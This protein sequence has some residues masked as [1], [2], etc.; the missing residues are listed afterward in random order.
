MNRRLI[1]LFFFSLITIYSFCQ[2]NILET[3]ISADFTD[4][5]LSS[6]LS[7]LNRSYGLNF[8]YSES[9]ISTDINVTV[10]M[11]DVT[12]DE[13]LREIFSETLI[14]YK[15]VN[16]RIVLYKNRNKY[17]KYTLSG[18]IRDSLTGERLI[19]AAVYISNPEY[20]TITNPYGFYSLTLPRGTY[21]INYMYIGYKP[22][23]TK[24]DLTEDFTQNIDLPLTNIYMPEVKIISTKESGFSSISEPG[25]INLETKNI[26]YHP[27]LFGEPDIA[28][29]ISMIPGVHVREMTS[30]NL[31]IRGGSSD[32]TVFYMDG[33][34]VFY[35]SHFGGFNSIFNSDAIHKVVVHKG[36]AEANIGEGLSSSI[37]VRMK[38]GNQKDF[39]ICGG[40]GTLA[41]RICV[42]GP[43]KKDHSSFIIS[44][45]RTYIDL[46]VKIFSKEF[47]ENNSLYFYDISIK[48]NTKINRTNKM[49]V[50]LYRGH[51]MFLFDTDI[52][53]INNIA[54]L[55][56]NHIYNP[57]LFMNVTTAVSKTEFFQESTY[58]SN[59]LKWKTNIMGIESK[60][61]LTWYHSPVSHSDMGGG[62][63]YQD[64]LPFRISSSSDYSGSVDIIG[65]QEI[66][67]KP[68]LYYGNTVKL[69]NKL[70]IYAGIRTT[71]FTE[72]GPEKKYI[73]ENPSDQESEVTDSV[74]YSRN[75]VVE[76]SLGIEPRINIS[77]QINST[78]S[79]K[80]S[81]GRT[82]MYTHMVSFEN[83]GLAIHRWIP[84]SKEFPF[85]KSDNYLIG[86]YKNLWNS[87][88]N[89]TSE[90]YYRNMKNLQ[91]SFS[92]EDLFLDESDFDFLH[93]TK[94]WSAGAE[95][96]FNLN[97]QKLNGSFCYSLSKT[98]LLSEGFNN[99]HYY[100]PGYDRRHDIKISG[101]WH[102]SK[103]LTLATKWVYTSGQPYTPPNG[104]YKIK[105]SWVAQ[106]DENDINSARLPDY[107]RL[108]VNIQLRSKKADMKRWKSYWN[109]GISNVYLR[110]NPMGVIYT[111]QSDDLTNKVMAPQKYY[112]Y[113]FVPSVSYNFTF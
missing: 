51:D 105:N 80:F 74:I 59:I 60:F 4:V 77:Y 75:Q 32:Q 97:I 1:F 112:F 23:G 20:G 30:S 84:S 87:R 94:G 2:E 71:L 99:N 7:E 78:N 44:A 102:I 46:L 109:F 67:L 34:P 53:R 27:S 10:H 72:T 98:R 81:Y 35:A 14:D 91:E 8:S 57:K 41:S 96:M 66:T 107:H 61:D 42:E 70:R 45:R 5:P 17:E 26:L 47:R 88:I 92:I 40:I 63:K 49:Y 85:Q 104:L 12:V 6:V 52:E 25:S 68:Y 79:V 36:N 48:G 64:F 65:D 110:R 101:L 22:V 15:I 89:I 76:S 62:L 86:Y 50:S 90:I 108:D 28:N 37:D 56:W 100:Y 21:D 103:R 18:F 43:I 82:H 33:A 16:T 39:K 73:H 93:K 95:F 3:R 69:W 58:L 29:S 31:F 54:T 38:E 9:I 55:R 11:N 113:L 19:G 83:F 106:I 24:I 13:M 111:D